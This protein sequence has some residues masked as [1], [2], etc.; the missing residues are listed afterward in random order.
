M[1][2]ECHWLTSSS[3]RWN[4]PQ[5]F[6]NVKSTWY[7]SLPCQTADQILGLIVWSFQRGFTQLETLSELIHNFFGTTW[8]RQKGFYDHTRQ[9][10]CSSFVSCRKVYFKRVFQVIYQ[11]GGRVFHQNI[12][13]WEV[14][15]NRPFPN[16]LRGLCVSHETA[17][18]VINIVFFKQLPILEKIQHKVELRN[19][20]RLNKNQSII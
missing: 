2:Y 13:A 5:T 16:P 10:N 9:R 6:D 19:V 18:A 20:R 7:V 12:N 14:G 1:Y 4:V 3:S 15:G 11:K 17:L 8:F